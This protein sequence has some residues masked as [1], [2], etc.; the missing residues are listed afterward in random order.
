MVFRCLLLLQD[1]AVE[2]GAGLNA[3][4]T[5][6]LLPL[7][8]LLPPHT[9]VL[10]EGGGAEAAA[11]A[12]VC[13]CSSSPRV[14]AVVTLAVTVSGLTTDNAAVLPLLLP[15]VGVVVV[16]VVVAAVVVVVVVAVVVVIPAGAAAATVAGAATAKKGAAVEPPISILVIAHVIVEAAVGADAPSVGRRSGKSLLRVK[17]YAS[18]SVDTGT[19]GTIGTAMALLLPTLP[20]AWMLPELLLSIAEVCAVCPSRASSLPLLGDFWRPPLPRRRPPL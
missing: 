10:M 16:V 19:G 4:D 3:A 8:P 12:V 15:H 6:L 17:L 5:A 9:V 20:L 7:P 1:V 2:L 11:G 18:S 13:R 14:K